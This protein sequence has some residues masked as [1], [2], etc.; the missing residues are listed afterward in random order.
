MGI[1]LIEKSDATGVWMFATRCFFVWGVMLLSFETEYFISMVFRTSWKQSF[2][3][4]LASGNCCVQEFQG[5]MQ[6]HRWNVC[7]TEQV[8]DAKVVHVPSFCLSKTYSTEMLLVFC[9]HLLVSPYRF[10]V[11]KLYWNERWQLRLGKFKSGIESERVSLLFQQDVWTSGYAKSSVGNRGQRTRLT[12][13]TSAKAFPSLS[14][15]FFFCLRI[16]DS[17]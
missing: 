9:L 16:L 2:S 1:N 4:N 7:V 6:T 14:S 17:V 3:S 11:I 8:V 15:S 13:S 12:T 5:L 10:D